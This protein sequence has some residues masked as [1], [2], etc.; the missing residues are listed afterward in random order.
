MNV[1]LFLLQAV[2]VIFSLLAG[3][4][5][6]TSATGRVSSLIPWRPVRVIPPAELPAFQAK[7]NSVAAA[8]ASVAAIAQAILFFIEYYVLHPLAG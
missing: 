7:F 1:A 4:F 3:G 5:W 8:C 2:L 6:I